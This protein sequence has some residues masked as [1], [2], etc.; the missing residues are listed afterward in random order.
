[1]W[2]NIIP[3][4]EKTE[5]LLGR[6]RLIRSDDYAVEIPL[7]LAQLAHKPKYPLINR[8]IAN[9]INMLLHSKLPIKHPLTL[10]RPTVWGFF[11]GSDYG[12]SWMW[13]TMMFG[14]FYVFFL[15]L[16]LISRNNFYLSIMGSAFLLFS[17]FFQFWSLHMAEIPI[18]MG[19]IFISF[20]CVCFS[21]KRATI[22]GN[23]ILLGWSLSCYAL[24]FPYP[25]F[26]ISC[27]YLLL[28]LIAGFMVDRYHDYN[29]QKNLICRLA[30]LVIALLICTYAV[31]T[32]YYATKDI[33]TIIAKTTYPGK[34]FSLGGDYALWR[35]FSNNYFITLLYTS[36]SGINW[37]PLGNICEGSSFLFFFPSIMLAILWHMVYRKKIADKFSAIFMGYFIIMLLYL[38]VGF[39]KTASKFSL[40]YLMPSCRSILGMG[41]ANVILIISFM[42]RAEH[43]NKIERTVISF[44]WAIL[45][46][47]SGM[48]LKKQFV[49]IPISYVAA[50]CIISGILSYYLLEARKRR[51]I[52][53]VFAGVSFLS[54]AWFNPVVVG[55]TQFLYENQLSKVIMQIDKA[56]KG[57]TMWISYSPRHFGNLFRILGIKSLVG[58]HSYPQLDLWEKFDREHKYFSVYNRYG[59]VI[60]RPSNSNHAEFHAPF[61]D[62]LVVSLNPSSKL[63][64]QIG[65]THILVITDDTL[66][67]DTA[68]NIKKIYASGNVHI[69]K[70]LL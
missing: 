19:L 15:V 65:V 45:L 23:S 66:L 70:I 13:W 48:G 11:L 59:E 43:T 30:G 1:M 64:H 6:E 5:I 18:F 46:F 38:F 33:I 37:R 28:F 20:S 39:P 47:C 32:Y 52:I 56:E 50:I 53:A 22:I 8:N 69:Y 62:L 14:L 60:F 44:L 58:T 34:R 17:P 27:G 26:Q 35:L 3:G 4:T 63:L 61:N 31:T 10:F 51:K 55:G 7:M 21:Q 9:G 54:S 16:M 49:Q 68:K 12:L 25:P 40:F 41:I 36:L 42:S 67:F 57:N 2:K 29:F 24:N